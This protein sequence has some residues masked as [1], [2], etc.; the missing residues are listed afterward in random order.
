MF[1]YARSNFSL[2]SRSLFSPIFDKLEEVESNA[3]DEFAALSQSLVILVNTICF[4]ASY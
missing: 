4:R 2:L 3:H 1:I